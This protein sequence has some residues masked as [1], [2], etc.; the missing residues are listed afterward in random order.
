MTFILARTSC[1]S[2]LLRVKEGEADALLAA[3]E[4][5]ID[6]GLDNVIFE[7]DSKIVAAAIYILYK[8]HCSGIW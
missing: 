7:V 2:P 3:V 1:Y 6:L 8:T 5:V 4:W